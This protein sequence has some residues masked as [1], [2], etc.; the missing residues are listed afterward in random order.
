MV[1]SGLFVYISLERGAD[2]EFQGRYN[3]KM[4]Q[5]GRLRLPSVISQKSGSGSY[6]I[7]NSLYKGEKC[8]DMYTQEGWDSFLLTLS[9]L[10][11]FDAN[12]QAFQ[13]FYISSAQSVNKDAQDRLLIPTHLREFGKLESQIVAIGMGSKVE[14]WN[15]NSWLKIFSEISTNYDEILLSVS[16]FQTEQK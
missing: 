8:L 9:D 2:L 12:I 15:E 11:K 6:V 14:L 5:K 7:T 4:D 3:L 1:K 10:P 13:R 16:K